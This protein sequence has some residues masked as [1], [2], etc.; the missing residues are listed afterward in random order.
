MSG[1]EST[2]PTG[3]IVNSRG[4]P[5]ARRLMI[6]ALV[7][8]VLLAAL[9]V[10]IVLTMLVLDWALGCNVGEG[11]KPSCALFGF[12]FGGLIAGIGIFSV[13]TS[14]VTVPLAGVLLAVWLIVLTVL[15]L[16]RRH[17]RAAVPAKRRI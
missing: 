6:W 11:D 16:L 17:G 7:A 1:E 3:S 15:L 10:L 4:A 12:D 2:R 5:M 14:L 8:I 9:P 13:W